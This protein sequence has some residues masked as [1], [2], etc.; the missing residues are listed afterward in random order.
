MRDI[1]RF[2]EREMK[3]M[4][5]ADRNEF[6]SGYIKNECPKNGL[7]S[8][9]VLATVLKFTLQGLHFLHSNNRVHRFE[10]V[11]FV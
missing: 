6:I 3:K 11:I 9:K 5:D 4:E 8:E 10:S 2:I 1:G 7:L